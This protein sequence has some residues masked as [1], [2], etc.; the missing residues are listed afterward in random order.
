MK[1]SSS[2]KLCRGTTRVAKPHSV[3]S[4][5]DINL[6]GTQLLAPPAVDAPTKEM[7]VTN[8]NKPD[9][10]LRPDLNKPTEM[11]RIHSAKRVKPTESKTDLILDDESKHGPEMFNFEEMVRIGR[12]ERDTTLKKPLAQSLQMLRRYK[13]G[14]SPAQKAGM[15][16]ESLEPIVQDPKAKRMLSAMSPRGRP[17]SPLLQQNNSLVFTDSFSAVDEFGN[18]FMPTTKSAPNL[19]TTS[20]DGANGNEVKKVVVK[21]S[22]DADLYRY[23]LSSQG[24]RTVQNKTGN[25]GSLKQNNMNELVTDSLASSVPNATPQDGDDASGGPVPVMYDPSTVRLPRMEIVPGF[26]STTPL[27]ESRLGAYRVHSNKAVS[28]AA[29]LEEAS[30]F[31][32][33]SRTLSMNSKPGAGDGDSYKPDRVESF[34]RSAETSHLFSLEEQAV[35]LQLRDIGGDASIGSRS[36]ETSIQ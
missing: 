5:E 20:A 27:V 32:G 25:F 4:A 15:L 31:E 12:P 30:V 28:A 1:K 6:N 29:A 21:Q 9:V 22:S 3:S 8:L 16:R 34:Y 2:T 23:H 24:K 19:R 11:Y 35:D 26:G 17:I 18:N 10:H 36:A 7:F 13:L 33:A 14:T